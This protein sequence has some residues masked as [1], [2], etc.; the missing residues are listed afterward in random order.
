VRE[1]VRECVYLYL[2]CGVY[3]CCT[4]MEAH[5]AK[6]VAM[7]RHS[8]L[9]VKTATCAHIDA[10]VIHER[11]VTACWPVS[12]DGGDGDEQD[13]TGTRQGKARQDK[14]WQHMAKQDK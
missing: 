6:G 1:Y 7:S 14:T 12:A 3:A 8:S 11:D 10:R 2:R 13:K 4:Q 5:T 9:C